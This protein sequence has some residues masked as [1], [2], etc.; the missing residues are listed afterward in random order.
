MKQILPCDEAVKLAHDTISPMRSDHTT[1]D[2]AMTANAYAVDKIIKER[3]AL[4]AELGRSVVLAEKNR[5]DRDLWKM[6]SDD[7]EKE[8]LR[9]HDDRKR[10]A[11][12]AEALA[13]ALESSQKELKLYLGDVGECDHSV[14]ICSCDLIRLIEANEGALS[15]RS[16]T[17]KEGI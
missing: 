15:F 4:K 13:G 1:W 12:R 8:I 11:S 9:L 16:A 6:R 5:A 14:G 2:A 10:W 7:A 3:D 17:Q